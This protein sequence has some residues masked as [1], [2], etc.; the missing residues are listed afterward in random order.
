[1]L[2]TRYFGKTLL[3]TTSFMLLIIVSL[4]LFFDFLGEF[5]NA[6]RHVVLGDILWMLL[7]RAPQHLYQTMPIAVLFGA[8]FG[9]GQLVR[10]SEYAVMRVSGLSLLQLTRVLS[11]VG[12]GFAAFTFVIG[13][14]VL[15]YADKVGIEMNLQVSRA[16]VQ[17]MM[18]SGVWVKD[19]QYIATFQSIGENGMHPR[20]I[21]LRRM[22]AQNHLQF[23]IVAESATPVADGWMLNNARKTRYTPEKVITESSPRLHWETSV[24]PILLTVMT[25][26]PERMPARQLYGFVRHLIRNHQSSHRQQIAFWT[27]LIYPLGCISMLLLALPFAQLQ[28]RSGGAG[29]R[30]LLGLMIGMGFYLLNQVFASIG[31]L[32]AWSPLYSAAAPTLTLLG[33]ALMALWWREYGRVRFGM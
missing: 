9:I 19:A 18:R 8:L 23:E 28:Q 1:M 29:V 5:A 16:Y 27:R 14:W 33:L 25:A 32:Q 12:L 3:R 6:D 31:L 4:M 17:T 24:N 2:I 26:S 20:G 30:L 15:P 10:D 21:T 11:T 22:N 13:E 7:L